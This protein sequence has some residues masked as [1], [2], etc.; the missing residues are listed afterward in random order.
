[1]KN[2]LAGVYY[3]M[4]ETGPI[5]KT[6]KR[7]FI[8]KKNALSV[9]GKATLLL[10]SPKSLEKE[11]CEQLCYAEHNL[12]TKNSTVNKLI[13]NRNDIANRWKKPVNGSMECTDAQSVQ[14]DDGSWICWISICQ[15]VILLSLKLIG[16]VYNF[17]QV[18][19]GLMHLWKLLH[20]ILSRRTLIEY[21]QTT[22][23]YSLRQGY[24][25][26][27]GGRHFRWF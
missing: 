1:M 9:E 7:I 23:I 19:V 4:V 24:Y 16:L 10:S 8:R 12:H 3:V 15:W 13:G 5:I 20:V 21:P 18:V 25:T 2:I 22:A 27:F 14:N 11:R 17:M 26:R 6:W